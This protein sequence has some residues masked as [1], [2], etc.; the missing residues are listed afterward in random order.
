MMY[1]FIVFWPD[2]FHFRA[3]RKFSQYRRMFPACMWEP[4]CYSNCGVVARATGGSWRIRNGPRKEAEN[5][6]D[7]SR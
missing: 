2:T 6:K 1:T 5:T 3:F 7:K 4:L